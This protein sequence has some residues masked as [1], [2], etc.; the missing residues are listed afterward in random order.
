MSPSNTPE[1]RSDSLMGWAVIGALAGIAGFGKLLLFIVAQIGNAGPSGAYAM[2]AIGLMACGSFA[3]VALGP[4]GRAVG[5]R[6][7]NGP[8]GTGA[9]LEELDAL[10]GEVEEMRQALAESHE[11]L[12]FAERMLT[13]S[14]DT[15]QP[16]AR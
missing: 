7:L 4:I 6:L 10:R 12:D 16:E 2:G 1:R 15:A 13:A 8:A 11:R 5:K 9:S 3:A 14:K